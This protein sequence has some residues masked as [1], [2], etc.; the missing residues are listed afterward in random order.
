[1]EDEMQKCTYCGADIKDGICKADCGWDR[2]FRIV[3]LK[4]KV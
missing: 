3:V 2:P 1:M 4:R